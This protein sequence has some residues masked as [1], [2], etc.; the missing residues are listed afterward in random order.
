M[1]EMTKD[2]AYAFL[3][4]RPGWMVLSTV[5]GEGY[6]HAVPLGYFRDGD[7]I[8]MTARGQRRA[9]ILRAPK[10]SLL[11]ESGQAMNELR[12][13]VIEGDASI[14]DAPDEV[15]RLARAAASDRGE[16]SDRWPTEVRPGTSYIRVAPRRL[17]SWD[18]TK[19]A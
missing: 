17:R 11:V 10:V 6:P 7:A 18:N 15:L 14:V 13:L 3:D 19:D 12:G 8:Y 2:E 9:N 4:S 1:A 16:P 5:G